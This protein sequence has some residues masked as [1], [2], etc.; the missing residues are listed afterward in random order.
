[1]TLPTLPSQGSTTWFDWAQGL[2]A[3]VRAGGG[4]T[5]VHGDDANV[6]RPSTTAAVVWFGSVEPT[7]ADDT[8]DVWVPVSEDGTGGATSGLTAEEIAVDP[9]VRAAYATAAPLATATGVYD[10]TRNLY[11]LKPAHLRRFRGRLA[12]AEAGTAECRIAVLG[13]SIAAGQGVTDKA[14]QN[15]PNAFRQILTA[16]GIPATTGPVMTN[17]G[18]SGTDPRWSFTGGTWT[19]FTPGGGFTDRTALYQSSSATAVATY[20]ST[21]PGTVAE[22]WYSN[23]SGAFTVAIDGGTAVTVTPAGGTSIARYQVTGLSN[24]VHTI[25]I[26]RTAG[27]L[28][29]AAACVRAANA[30]SVGTFGSGGATVNN[31]QQASQPYDLRAFAI[32][33]APHL[34]TVGFMTNDANQSV[35]PETYGLRLQSFVTALVTAGV[36]ILLIAEPPAN[37]L[38]LAPFRTVLYQIA[39]TNDL[40]VLDLFDRW[41]TYTSANSL[42]LMFDGFHPAAPGYRDYGRAVRRAL[43][44]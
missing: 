37:G 9:T 38:D 24:A 41:G 18:D 34:A 16:E 42:G 13:T 4:N 6:A 3:A 20:T 15:W 31:F 1:M 27:T 28:Y 40:P 25:T 33:W 44:P 14:T 22:V 30:V 5:V 32:S 12:A 17:L 29:L 21:T 2:D 43:I 8:L 10:R 11:N 19:K 39:D 26:T 36:D 35:T 7:N 23:G